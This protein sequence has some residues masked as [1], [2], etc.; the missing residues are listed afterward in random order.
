VIEPHDETSAGAGA[1]QELYLVASGAARFT[2]EG[3]AVEAPAGTLIA[4]EPGVKREAIATDDGTTIVV[5][6][7]RPDSALPPSP[8]EFWYYPP[9]GRATSNELTRS[10]PRGSSNGPSTGR[11]TTSSGPCALAWGVETRRL[12]TCESP[13]RTTRAH[14]NGLRRTTSSTRSATPSRASSAARSRDRRRGGPC[15]PHVGLAESERLRKGGGPVAER[16]GQ[17]QSFESDSSDESVE[18]RFGNHD[19]DRG[20][21]R[22]CGYRMALLRHRCLLLHAHWTRRH[23]DRP[24]GGRAA[25]TPVTGGIAARVPGA[26]RPPSARPA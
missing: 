10:S 16:G 6:G 3:E 1:H 7:G 4:V 9:S 23:A 26:L 24:H 14:A 2:V 19:W 11:S 18:V 8:F 25:T 5:I 22:G 21:P 20:P 12:G 15:A 13:S 17:S